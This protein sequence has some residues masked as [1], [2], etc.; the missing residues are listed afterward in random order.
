[1]QSQ[2][3]ARLKPFELKNQFNMVAKDFAPR[4]VLSMARASWRKSFLILFTTGFWSLALSV[5][6]NTNT[7]EFETPPPQ[8]GSIQ[9]DINQSLAREQ[10]ERYRKHVAI[11]DAV[12]E[13]IPRSAFAKLI[14]GPKS[15]DA[16]MPA[17]TALIG[18]SLQ[19]LFF[20][21]ACILTGILTVRKCAPHFFP[22]LNRQLNP[23]ALAPS[24][25][26]GLSAKVRDEEEAFG[27]FL[28][29]FRTG[30]ATE[31]HIGFSERENPLAEFY[32]RL[33]KRLVVEQKFLQNIAQESSDQARRRMLT[34]LYFE[35]GVLKG[36]A[37]L[38]ET[39]PIWQAASA[40]E[41][42]LK[43]LTGK[44]RNITTST[45]RTLSAGMDLLND[46]CVPGLQPNLLTEPPL[47]FLVVDDDRIS[48]QALSLSL[49]RVFSEPDLA[50]NGEIALAQAR[51]QAYDVIFLDVQMPGMDGFELCTKIRNTPLN[52]AT[53][54]VFVTRQSDFDARA[55]STLSGGNDL[56]AKPFLT[57]E[58]TVKALTLGLQ[59]RLQAR[60]QKLL[61]QPAQGRETVDELVTVTARSRP[62]AKATNIVQSQFS[63]PPETVSDT[64]AFLARVSKHIGP[65]R[66]LCQTILQTPDEEARQSLL[67]DGFLRINSFIP[68]NG[69]EV[70]HPAYQVSTALEGLFRKLLQNPKHST[71][72]TLVTVATAVELLNDLCVPGIK[73]DLGVNPPI[74]MLV[75]DDDLVTRRVMV[76]A[77]QIAF[78]KPESVENGDAAIALA[79]EKPFDVIFLDVVM[80]GMDGFEVCSKIRDTVPNHS[81]PVVFMTGH[82]DFD[83]RTQMGRTGGNDLIG[84]P[85]LTSE[86]T[87]KALTFALRGRLQQFETQRAN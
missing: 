52:C 75:V 41:G 71:P 22:D 58:V 81:T 14:N 20:F 46:L 66:E 79:V 11:P 63:V 68:A 48:C 25:G 45:L 5:P 8:R 74:H 39:L 28:T 56:L 60:A 38:P 16:P 55:M 24:A 7:Y 43:Q 87:V 80:P 40:L 29:A 72:S 6:T 73:A 67:A 50:T 33:K 18:N 12:G 47:R 17:Q 1:L 76:G 3:A 2:V 86:I 30:P 85:F 31:Q 35:M 36:E 27:K 26:M 15:G 77:L 70:E 4:M 42:L 44:V 82:D 57:F 69:S 61:P 51:R 32:A 13:D 49:K 21:A 78:K 59:S 84:K 10:Q 23:W 54:V 9:W 64:V 34:Y 19:T 62:V 65:L 37:E 53:P 83:T